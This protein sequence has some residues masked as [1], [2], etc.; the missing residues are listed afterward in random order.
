MRRGSTEN[1]E[2]LERDGLVESAPWVF[3]EEMRAKLVRLAC[4]VCGSRCAAEDVVHDAYVAFASSHRLTDNP[5]AY[6]YV[7][8]I[9]RS[10]SHL[11]RLR[12]T[13]LSFP[14]A[15]MPATIEMQDSL[16]DALAKLPRRQLTAVIARF[17]LDLDD[18]RTA[19]LLG[20]KRSTVR[21]LIQR[22]T[23]QLR[24]ELA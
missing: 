10:R 21:T 1:G 13:R 11:R 6:L 8:V 20:V 12:T 17:Y 14:L 2:R 23:V 9:N 15:R 19:Q 7:A 18:E 22:A 4:S 5:E 24:K 16:G 3:D